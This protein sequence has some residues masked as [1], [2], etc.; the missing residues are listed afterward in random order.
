[1]PIAY[2]IFWLIQVPDEKPKTEQKPVQVSEW[3]FYVSGEVRSKF[4]LQSDEPDLIL[5]NYTSYD[6]RPDEEVMFLGHF[7]LPKKT[8]VDAH[9]YFW[10]SG[11]KG[12][13]R[14]GLQ[15]KV[16]HELFKNFHLGYGHHS[17]H[18][19]DVAGPSNGRQQDWALANYYFGQAKV[20]PVEL[21]FQ[22]EIRGYFKNNYPAEIK[23]FY[24]ISDDL[25][26][27]IE[28]AAFVQAKFRG[29]ILSVWPSQQFTSREFSDSRFELKAELA[30]QLSEVFVAF[31][32]I[33]Y[34]R[35]HG[36]D[37]LNI[38]IGLGIKFK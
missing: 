13:S 10:Y 23:S 19:T 5:E 30:Y 12:I 26:A 24:G 11:Y 31:S 33:W 28:L 4:F 22:G 1:M 7:Q 2:A 3:E 15:I 29:F 35:I 18:N 25:T 9:P 21:E 37:R 20:G 14:I 38:G 36:E 27:R 8:T 16:Q 6:K 32:D 34:Y 17:W